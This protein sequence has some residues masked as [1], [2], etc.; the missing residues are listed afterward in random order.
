MKNQLPEWATAIREGLAGFDMTAWREAVGLT[1]AQAADLLGL[2]RVH[3][4]RLERGESPMDNRTKMACL[5]LQ[6]T[7][8]KSIDKPDK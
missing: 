8:N 4:G 6:H 5:Y 7:A 1:Q 3:L 2:T